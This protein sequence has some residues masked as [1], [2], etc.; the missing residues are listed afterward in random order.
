MVVWL[1][2][3]CLWTRMRVCLWLRC[4][5]CCCFRCCE[6]LFLFV[7]FGLVCARVRHSCVRRTNVD[8]KEEK[9]SIF[10]GKKN[11]KIRVLDNVTQT[12]SVCTRETKRKQHSV[13]HGRIRAQRT[14]QRR[15]H[16]CVYIHTEKITKPTLLVGAFA[17]S[18]R[19]PHDFVVH[20]RE[21]STKGQSERAWSFASM[22]V[23]FFCAS[24]CL[25]S[26]YLLLKRTKSVKNVRSVF[27]F[28]SLQFVGCFYSL[29]K[30]NSCCAVSR[31]IV[32]ILVCEIPY[33]IIDKRNAWNRCIIDVRTSISE[34]ETK[35]ILK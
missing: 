32:W 31:R 22:D 6:I 23:L 1:A 7:R 33:K 20:A 28:E 5:C 18:L 4:S 30:L 14:A 17:R 11:E 24:F 8:H 12:H 13:Q 35:N 3:L 29:V 27:A 10:C 26:N 2:R 9:Q 21:I 34:I 16:L 19:A 25:V 15:A